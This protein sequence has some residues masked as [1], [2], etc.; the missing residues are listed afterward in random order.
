MLGIDIVGFNLK[1]GLSCLV[2]ESNDLPTD[3]KKRN[4]REEEAVDDKKRTL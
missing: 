1:I 4:E 3:C 2:T